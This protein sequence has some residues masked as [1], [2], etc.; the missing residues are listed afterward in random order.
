[1][2]FL[3]G[4]DTINNSLALLVLLVG[5]SSVLEDS[6]PDNPFKGKTRLLKHPGESSICGVWLCEDT[7]KTL[8]RKGYAS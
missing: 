4:V 7:V 6:S 2:H 1:M 5:D 8:H 3:T